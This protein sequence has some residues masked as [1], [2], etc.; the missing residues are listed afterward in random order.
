M[1]SNIERHE[2][3]SKPEAISQTGF[4]SVQ[5]S[6]RGFLAFAA[7]ALAGCSRQSN[8]HS[9][10]FDVGPNDIVTRG[11]IITIDGRRVGNVEGP[12]NFGLEVR[13]V[14]TTKDELDKVFLAL[15]A[16]WIRSH[17]T[18]DV[19]QDEVEHCREILQRGKQAILDEAMPAIH[20]NYYD[21]GRLF[22]NAPEEIGNIVVYCVVKRVKE[23][24]GKEKK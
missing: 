1:K 3:G 18:L 4:P 10:T 20:Y 2:I 21:G 12:P 11:E 15:S 7:A 16:E 9:V 5:V 6:R 23:V 19:T 22:A 24:L 17:A 13:D 8:G 14:E